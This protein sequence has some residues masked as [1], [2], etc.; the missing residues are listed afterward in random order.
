MKWSVATTTL[1]SKEGCEK[2]HINLYSSLFVATQM[3][4]QAN[5]RDL[6]LQDISRSEQNRGHLLGLMSDR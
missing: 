4:W 3:N 1:G 5:L 6:G 2:A